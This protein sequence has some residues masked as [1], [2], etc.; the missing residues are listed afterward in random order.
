MHI[1]VGFNYQF[2][3]HFV[4]VLVGLGEGALFY[5]VNVNINWDIKTNKFFGMFSEYVI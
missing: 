3:C 1:C 5:F 2:Y 4:F